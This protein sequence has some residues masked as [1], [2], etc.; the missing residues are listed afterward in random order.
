MGLRSRTPR[1]SMGLQPHR[2]I[3]RKAEGSLMTDETTRAEAVTIPEGYAL[4]PIKHT[5]AMGNAG[6]KAALRLR[7]VGNVWDA[8]V[9]AAPVALGVADASGFAAG[10][11]AAAKL[12]EQNQET[13]SSA[14]GK[15]MTK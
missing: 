14:V 7:T 1:C 11:E 9:A 12:V 5:P 13:D 6:A 3:G 10:I 8:M 15:H 2:N 4:L